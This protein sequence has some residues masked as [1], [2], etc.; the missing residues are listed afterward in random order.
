MAFT[1]T[2]PGVTGVV[3]LD[4]TTSVG[5][6][7]ATISLVAFAGSTPATTGDLVFGDGV[8]PNVTLRDCFCREPRNELSPNAAE[9]TLELWD[10]RWRWKYGYA[11]DGHWNQEAGSGKLVPW[12]VRSP[13][14]LAYRLLQLMGELVD[15]SNQIDLPGGLANP[16]LP[17]GPADVPAR[18]AGLYLAMGQNFALTKTNPTVQWGTRPAAQCLADLC[19]YYGRLVYLDYGDDR[20]RIRQIGDD[21]GLALPDGGYLRTVTTTQRDVI[22][23][24][25]YARGTADEVQ[26]RLRLRPV[27]R[28][29]DRSWRPVNQVSYAPSRPGQ[30]MKCAAQGNTFAPGTA[31]AVAVNGVTFTVPGGTAANFGA[32]ATSLAA[33]INGSADPKVAGVVTAAVTSG[34]LTVEATAMGPEFEFT[35]TATP[36]DP[37]N[38]IARCLAGPMADTYAR[39]N[40]WQVTYGAPFPAGC[41]YGVTVSDGT[42]T[43]T[44]TY[45]PVGTGT[46]SV[47]EATAALAELVGAPVAA[48][49]AGGGATL[50]VTGTTPGQTLTVTATSSLGAAPV[51]TEVATTTGP[52]TGWERCPGPPFGVFAKA[53]DRLN[54]E[55]AKR[56]ANESVYT[57]YQVVLEDPADGRVK[58]IPVPE[59]GRITNQFLLLLQPDSPEPVTPEPGLAQVLDVRTL[60]PA[61]LTTYNGFAVRR[62]NRVYGSVG[63]H[64]LARDGLLW[65]GGFYLGLNTPPRQLLPITFSVIDPEQQIVQFSQPVYRWLGTSALRLWGLNIPVPT[66]GFTTQPAELVIE[67]GALVLDPATNA[68]RATSYGVAVPDGV[69]PDVVRVFPDIRREVLGVYDAR[70]TLTGTRTLDADARVRGAYY[71]QGVAD[72]FQAPAGLE[73]QYSGVKL[74][75]LSGAVRQ[76]RWTLSPT[77]PGA[78]TTVGVNAETSR[79]VL[80]YFARR[81]AENLP[82]DATRAV[83]NLLSD[84]RARAAQQN[85]LRAAA[86]GMPFP[87]GGR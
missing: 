7:P 67:C 58:S 37:A 3:S 22:P 14:Q 51:V 83:Q 43:R 32:V 36:A 9:V 53:T 61:G 55:E 40:A 72:T 60:Q 35:A 52:A 77:E 20:V 79:V 70:H 2:Y 10:R 45:T 38:W 24:N 27:A 57:C 68:P 30:K 11:A 73:R 54:H 39:Q 47:Y 6:S 87:G 29:W 25:V 26:L 50:V 64:I 48:T 12:T 69:G 15:P 28:E 59:I 71:A 85:A 41:V 66:T 78:A 82:Q 18:A 1:I 49:A 19:E 23:A 13:W 81:R 31:Y 33:Q 63:W 80:P 84:F 75:R 74:V 21:G 5:I 86:G 44:W 8:N 42:N 76:V 4:V 62:P 17:M 34:V 46:N 16:D 56:L 65:R